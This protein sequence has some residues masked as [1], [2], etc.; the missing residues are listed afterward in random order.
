M[1]SK[2]TPP[3]RRELLN[4]ETQAKLDF[5]ALY[6]E[7]LRAQA[8]EQSDKPSKSEPEGHIKIDELFTAYG[9]P[10]A[11]AG[12]RYID[13]HITKPLFSYGD[14]AFTTRWGKWFVVVVFLSS[15]LTG[16]S[17]SIYAS[18]TIYAFIAGVTFSLAT[19]PI[20]VLIPSAAGGFLLFGTAYCIFHFVWK[21]YQQNKIKK[22]NQCKTVVEN[23]IKTEHPPAA[24][25]L[26]TK[27]TRA[28]Q[29]VTTQMD[30]SDRA[31]NILSS[32]GGVST[33]L[34]RAT[35]PPAST[36]HDTQTE[37]HQQT[38]TTA[39][40]TKRNSQQQR[41]LFQQYF[42]I[43][44]EH[45]H[46]PVKYQQHMW[47]LCKVY[48]SN[49]PKL[50]PNSIDKPTLQAF[51]KELDRIVDLIIKHGDGAF[52]RKRRVLLKIFVCAIS[53]IAGGTGGAYAAALVYK[54]IMSAS[55][56]GLA[57][58][59][60]LWL[61]VGIT[62]GVA[63]AGLAAYGIYFAIEKYRDNVALIEERKKEVI[64]RYTQQ[65]DRDLVSVP[66]KAVNEV[67][68]QLEQVPQHMRKAFQSRLAVSG[69][70]NRPNPNEE[71]SS[72]NTI[73]SQAGI[74]IQIG[75]GAGV[76]SVTPAGVLIPAEQ[77]TQL[78][79]GK[80]VNINYDGRAITLTLAQNADE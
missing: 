50:D 68:N 66:Y 44:H 11:E 80:P 33:Q 25:N 77:V 42:T 61:V 41:I 75:V 67:I 78:F 32:T 47:A 58:T 72:G 17:A 19:T 15:G 74:L 7:G 64:H 21:K 3:Q 59:P 18:A 53:G 70:R 43:L 38:K 49:G 10:D 34:L 8:G 9:F 51:T 6:I 35:Q 14:G 48:H 28:V 2:L 31:K 76:N 1:A 20:W 56:F 37:S 55:L 62:I 36:R 46:D 40:K 27:L 63:I 24:T 39:V 69:H 30:T 57:Y 54:V 65:T 12:R 26:V 52:K 22:I 5:L 60:V 73:S 79:Q 13:E 29:A 16:L 23:S 45:A 71:S 4:N